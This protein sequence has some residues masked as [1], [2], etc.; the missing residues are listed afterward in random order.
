MEG[1]EAVP[2]S[3]VQDRRANERSPHSLHIRYTQDDSKQINRGKLVDLNQNGAGIH[4]DLPLLVGSRLILEVTSPS[5]GTARCAGEV[6]HSRRARD[7]TYRAGVRFID[8]DEKDQ[9]AIGQILQIDVPLGREIF[10][11]NP[12]PE[13]DPLKDLPSG[14]ERRRAARVAVN[15]SISYKI[16]GA[17]GRVQVEGV[18]Q[19]FDLSLNGVG[20]RTSSPIVQGIS[21]QLEVVYSGGLRCAIEA[22]CIY[23]RMEGMEK[24]T[25]GLRFTAIERSDLSFFSKLL[26]G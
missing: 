25:N 12:P 22:E 24:Y 9:N 16:F 2:R 4:T 10:P 5:G 26:A 15:R 6:L 3:S 11:E 23:C 1:P 7:R 14:L 18:A 20:L 8:I 21:L 13:P 17:R 19:L